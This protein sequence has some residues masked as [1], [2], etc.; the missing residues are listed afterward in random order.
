MTIVKPFDWTYT[1]LHPGTTIIPNSLSAS[2][3]GWVPASPDHPGIP[4]ALLARTDIS[5]LFFDEI[6]LFEDELGDNG[7]ADVT[8]RVVSPSLSSL[9]LPPALTH[10]TW[11]ST[12]CKLDLLLRTRPILPSNRSRPIP[13][14]RCPPLPLFRIVRTSS[15]TKRSS[16]FIRIYQISSSPLCTILTTTSSLYE[17]T[18]PKFEL[19][20]NL[21]ALANSNDKL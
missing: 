9:L 7:I 20:G 17:S 5:I 11:N 16:I 14:L 1:T 4:L 6:P 8:I 18:H 19:S 13:T 2:P 12:A 10:L 15:R 3:P 21:D